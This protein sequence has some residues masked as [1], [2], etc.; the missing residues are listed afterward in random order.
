MGCRPSWYLSGKM[1]FTLLIYKNLMF[2]TGR[3]K[4]TCM[5]YLAPFLDTLVVLAVI[6]W[7]FLVEDG[8]TGLILS[9]SSLFIPSSQARE[10][11][12]KHVTPAFLSLADGQWTCMAENRDTYYCS[13]QCQEGADEVSNSPNRTF[14]H[15]WGDRWIEPETT[16]VSLNAYRYLY[17]YPY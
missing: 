17:P 4:L 9:I 7:V 1:E 6:S 15:P 10:K 5:F 16:L 11:C 12:P 3:L 2:L 8:R 13:A 14:G